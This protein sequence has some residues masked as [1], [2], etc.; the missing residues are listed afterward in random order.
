MKK[1]S[2][3]NTTYVPKKHTLDI[4]KTSNQKKIYTNYKANINIE[5]KLGESFA[6][7]NSNLLD[8][9]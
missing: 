6:S 4:F 9:E 5:K 3:K 2:N 7:A 8:E 1:L